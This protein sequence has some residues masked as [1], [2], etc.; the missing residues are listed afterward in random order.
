MAV[1]PGGRFG[2]D[3]SGATQASLAAAWPP[4]ALSALVFQETIV[5]TAANTPLILANP[6]A[7]R[8]YLA[9]YTAVAANTIVLATNRANLLTTRGIVSTST[10]PF[11]QNWASNGSAVNQTWWG[12]T[13]NITAVLIHE[14]FYRPNGVIYNRQEI[15][16]A[17]PV[18]GNE[19]SW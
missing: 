5:T 15:V 9:I 16:E 3:I 7:D 13:G 11:V 4:E 19:C 1:A 14:Q 8:I 17:K 12:V 6:S 18:N 2:N 10:A